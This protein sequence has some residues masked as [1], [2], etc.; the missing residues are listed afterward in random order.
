MRFDRIPKPCTH[1][2]IQDRLKSVTIWTVTAVP[3]PL[4]QVV[5]SFL[6]REGPAVVGSRLR[7]GG[8]VLVRV[9]YLVVHDMMFYASIMGEDLSI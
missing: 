7:L 8:S 6:S 9:F 2:P 3:P 1:L 4:L 5:I